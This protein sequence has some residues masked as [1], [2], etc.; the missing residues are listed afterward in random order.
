MDNE[1]ITVKSEEE[2]LSTVEKTA[3]IHHV[4]FAPKTFD[5][6]IKFSE[7]VAASDLAPKDFRGKPA[8]V[9][10]AIQMGMELGLAPM[11]AIQNIAVINGRP[12]LWGD[13]LLAL[14]QASPN[15]EWHREWIEGEGDNQK[16]IC[17][18]KRRDSIEPHQATFSVADAK[19]A[20]LWGKDSPWSTYPN[21]MLQMRARAFC[22]RDTFADVLRGLV[23]AEEAIDIQATEVKQV[24][25]PRRKSQATEPEP[26]KTEAQAEQ[27]DKGETSAAKSMHQ[28]KPDP[29][30]HSAECLVEKVEIVRPEGKKPFAAVQVKGSAIPFIVNNEEDFEIVKLLSGR[31]A[32]FDFEEK[33]LGKKSV[34]EVIEFWNAKEPE[35][36]NA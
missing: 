10:I 31:W 36:A 24:R 3:P 19:R 29:G 1:I 22:A 34:R 4:S 9:L 27:P 12:S 13:A 30:K 11:Q 28:D 26:P 7:M 15:Y 2:R 21:R 25:M 18:M 32:G 35:K 14:V 5:E 33:M 8:N 20:K 23:P 16:A 6:A 17:E